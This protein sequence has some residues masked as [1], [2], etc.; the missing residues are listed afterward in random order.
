MTTDL[1]AAR[2]PE[3]PVL[4]RTAPHETITLRIDACDPLIAAGA[5]ETLRPIPDLHVMSREN[6]RTADVVLVLVD[7]IDTATLMRVRE[8]HAV[9]GRPVVLL[10]TSL[11]EESALA[12][13][14]AG[15]RAI[16]RRSDA[17]P[18]RL[19]EYLRTAVRGDGAVPGDIL[20]RL[21][22]QLGRLRAQVLAPL[23]VRLNG[24]TEREIEVLRLVA[25]G[26]ETAE[27]A[28]RLNYSQRTIKAVLHDVTMRLCLRNR[29]H[30]V[31]YAVREGLI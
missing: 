31:A 28:T 22:D 4:G 11:D 30:A 5:I 23:G 15:A 3:R 2:T 20:G 1:I 19:A 14:E 9:N 13:V 17:T 21:L 25:E 27:I 12:A 18:Q 29:T 24:M 16:L 26:L 10:T 8:A 6:G 7:S